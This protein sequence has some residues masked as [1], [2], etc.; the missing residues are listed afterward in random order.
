MINRELFRHI[1]WILIALLL[2]ISL[3]G[4]LFI[5]SSS[6]Y[7]P[8]NF[9]VRQIIWIVISLG[10]MFLFLFIDYHNLADYSHIAYWLM[11]A[12]LVGILIF[13]RLTAGTKSWIHFSF[14]QVQ[15]SE[16]MKIVLILVLGHYFADHRREKISWSEF[17]VTSSLVMIPFILVAFQPDL[18]TASSFLTIFLGVL[19]LAGLNKK[20][21]ILSLILLLLFGCLG[22]SFFLHDYQKER[23]ITLINPQ[24]DPLGSG[25][26]L[27]QSKIAVGSGGLLGKGFMKGTQSQ[28]RFLPAR[29]TDFIFS[30]IGEEIGFVGA[31]VI[32]IIYVLFLYRI[33]KTCFLARDRLGVY[34]VFMVAVM[35]T[36]QFFINIFMTIGLFP[37]TGIPLPFISYGGSS[38]FSNYLAISLVLNVRMRRFVNI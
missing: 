34:L 5:Y 36:C 19:I 21:F 2:V 25:Y 17:L 6:H 37:V 16:L 12:V 15:P 9:H 35:L 30:V 11:T 26:Q 18:G 32:I 20:I 31:A 24:S 13:G 33:Y 4:V 8:G 3:V 14:F 10:V 7:L 27:N 29:H 28:L 23:L 22:W 1:D 38:L